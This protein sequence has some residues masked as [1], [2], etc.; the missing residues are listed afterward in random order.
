M[1]INQ[2]NMVGRIKA[3]LPIRWFPA[4]T[5]ILDTVLAGPANALYEVHQLIEWIRRQLRLHT[6]TGEALDRL[7]EG[8]FADTLRR[9]LYEQDDLF[10]RRAI[11]E[12]LRD[13][14]TRYATARAILDLTDRS[15]DIFEPGHCGDTGSYGDSALQSPCTMAYGTAG[16]WGSLDHPFQ[17]FVTA[18]R[19]IGNGVSGALGWGSG[20]YN[21]GPLSYTDLES[22]R[23]HISDQ[24]IH[25]A[26][27][28]AL[29]I[30]T[31]AWVRISG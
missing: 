11:K 28:R 20:G 9:R 12:M 2:S 31:I 16:R 4:S 26:L 7:V 29:P 27:R 23:G 1:V 18:Y 8:Y 17:V 14:A 10:R 13:R 24:D 21:L 5:P 19:P 15:P 25:D 6:A 3:L 30:G 22:T